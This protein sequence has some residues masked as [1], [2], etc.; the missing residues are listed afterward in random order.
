MI[1][2]IIPIKQASIERA[3]EIASQYSLIDFT[4]PWGAIA[5]ELLNRKE[6]IKIYEQCTIDIVPF[7]SLDN[8]YY[9]AVSESGEVM[10]HIETTRFNWDGKEENLPTGGW[11]GVVQESYITR[12]RGCGNSLSLIYAEVKPIY[13]G[14]AISKQLITYVCESAKADR[15]ES[16]VVPARPPLKATHQFAEMSI[17]EF[18]LLKREDGTHVDPW[19]RTH[20]SCGAKVLKGDI[21]HRYC[22]SI[23]QF[24][25]LFNLTL[26]KETGN[27]LV[28]I[29]VMYEGVFP[30]YVDLAHNIVLMEEYCVWMQY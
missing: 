8:D 5:S 25:R 24:E 22:F 23:N 3:I 19:I 1:A 28:D 27:Q 17:D 20:L 10:G 30:V 2:R 29:K 16:I 21:S 4:N 15:I 9:F 6:R 26:T 13:R 7:L 11:T 18:V 12:L 14:A